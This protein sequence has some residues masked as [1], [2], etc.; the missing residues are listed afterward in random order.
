MASC[1]VYNRLT[2]F[3]GHV[4]QEGG[5]YNIYR[6]WTDH[7]GWIEQEGGCHTVNQAETL[8]C[9]GRV[10]PEGED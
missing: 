7:V 2:E 10:R 4:E 6:G 5:Y 9:I 3:L 8:R 1:R